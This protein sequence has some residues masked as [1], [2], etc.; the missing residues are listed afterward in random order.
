MLYLSEYAIQ[1]KRARIRAPMEKIPK[2]LPIDLTEKQIMY[3]TDHE[4]SSAVVVIWIISAQRGY[5]A[6]HSFIKHK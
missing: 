6:M 5:K 3:I 1:I 2:K 4:V